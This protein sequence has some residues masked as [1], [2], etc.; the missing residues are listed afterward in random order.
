MCKLTDKFANLD[1]MIAENCRKKDE[2]GEDDDVIDD[3]DAGD[4]FLRESKVAPPVEAQEVAFTPK[5]L[6]DT[7]SGGLESRILQML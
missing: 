6:K 4:V 3:E 5:L 2:A 1:A 7:L